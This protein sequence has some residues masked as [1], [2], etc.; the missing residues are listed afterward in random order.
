MLVLVVEDEATAR[1]ATV[2]RLEGAGYEVL[3]AATAADA[4]R[5][6]EMRGDEVAAVFVTLHGT[7]PMDGLGL[8]QVVSERWPHIRPSVRN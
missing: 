1:I 7:V 6:L 5:L 2:N 3:T 8:M 4:L